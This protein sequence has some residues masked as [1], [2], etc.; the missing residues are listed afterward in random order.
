MKAIPFVLAFVLA[1][2][3]VPRLGTHSHAFDWLGVALSAVGMF[4]I[5]FGVQEGETYDWG[6]ISGLVSVPLL[7]AVGVVVFALFLL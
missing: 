7:I 2:R 3:L 5:V 4:L 6:T 1:A